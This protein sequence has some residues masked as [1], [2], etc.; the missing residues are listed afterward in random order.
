MGNSDKPHYFIKDGIAYVVYVGDETYEGLADVHTRLAQD[1]AFYPEIPKLLDD[2]RVTDFAGPRVLMRIR[3]LVATFHAGAKRKR[4][5]A[6]VSA[7][8]FAGSFAHIYRDLQE[9]G[10]ES[11]MVEGRIFETIEE[12][13]AWLKETLDK[14]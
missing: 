1:P 14:S 3:D 10:P 7:D 12:A 4:R 9:S 2:R 11:G 13:E 8:K 6:S 5:I